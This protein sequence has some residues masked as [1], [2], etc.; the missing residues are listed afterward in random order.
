MFTI[1]SELTNKFYVYHEMEEALEPLGFKMADNWDYDHGYF[2]YKIDNHNG[3]LFL[4]IPIEV[5]GGYLDSP[6]EANMVKI[7]APFLLYHQFQDGLDDHVREGNIRASFDQFQEPKD[8]DAEF[9]KE[10]IEAGRK[11]LKDAEQALRS[12]RNQ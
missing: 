7:K 11:A 4:R 12:Q 6:D 9:P 1:E 3:Y 2:D 10:Y 8:R 5:M